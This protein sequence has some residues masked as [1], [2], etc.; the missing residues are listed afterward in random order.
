MIKKYLEFINESAN[1]IIGHTSSGKPIYNY[2]DENLYKNFTA[3]DHKEAH[4]LHERIA[5]NTNEQGETE[6][7]NH[8]VNQMD[9]HD[10]KA[11]NLFHMNYLK[12]QKSMT[13][14]EKKEQENFIKS[15]L[16]KFGLKR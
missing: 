5:I 16:N 6:L 15:K 2:Y 8:H 13:S 3:E 11:T 12:N 4:D 14:K 7:S 9:K 10:R 1:K